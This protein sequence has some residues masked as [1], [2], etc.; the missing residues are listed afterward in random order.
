MLSKIR[1]A[2]A[3]ALVVMHRHAAHP[4]MIRWRPSVRRRTIRNN[5]ESAQG[6]CR[7]LVGTVDPDMATPV[8]AIMKMTRTRY[9]S[10]VVLAL[11]MLITAESAAMAGSAQRYTAAPTAY[12][13]QANPNYG[14]GPRV[15]VHPHDVI[16]G[17]RIVGRDPDPFIRGEI[18][19]AYHNGWSN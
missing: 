11:A 10:S 12:N 7:P 4:P 8:H 15:R 9:R 1:L 14:F 3:L 16:S 17:D 5:S 6:H 19:R 2:L 13:V 18:L